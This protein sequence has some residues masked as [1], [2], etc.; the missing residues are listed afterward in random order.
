MSFLPIVERE[1]RVRSRKRLVYRV[2]FG[3]ALLTCILTMVLL[4]PMAASGNLTLGRILFSILSWA[5]FLLAFFSG[6]FL[7]VDSFAREQREGTLGL[8]FLTDLQ[9]WD[10][11]LG[12]FVSAF[13][14]SFYAMIA[15]FP[16]M[17]IPLLTGGVAGGEFWRVSLALVLTL[18]FSLCLG[19][20]ISSLHRHEQRAFAQM[21]G[22]LFVLLLLPPLTMALQR[23]IPPS[24]TGIL[25]VEQL[26][27]LHLFI[28]AGNPI[29]RD[30]WGSFRTLAFVTALLLATAMF[31]VPRL[32]QERGLTPPA[33]KP[34]LRRGPIGNCDPVVWL[35][36]NAPVV[37]SLAWF[38]G[39]GAFVT[40]V[41]LLAGTVPQQV[42]RTLA[43][44][45]FSP[46]SLLL[47][48]LFVYQASR[49]FTD[50]RRNSAIELL[51]TTPVTLRDLANGQWV[52]LRKIFMGP[53]ILALA[54]SIIPI[55]WIGNQPLLANFVQ[56]VG[57]G[58]L[59]GYHLVVIAAEVMALGWTGMWLS[60]RLK[61]PGWA[62]ALA[63]LLVLILPKFLFCLPSFISSLVLA[64]VMRSQLLD[65]SN[66]LYR[67]GV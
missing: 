64:A 19:L 27:P 24:W 33:Q 22:G 10:V 12:K 25:L 21:A 60:L 57:G 48:I 2:R 15:T 51:A 6:L 18:L 28:A 49:L 5:V 7:T 61:N 44:S 50:L 52:S 59:W 11:V 55:L 54:G 63:V 23:L 37:H 35:T 65:Y 13:L 67:V 46:F 43:W 4:L 40:V 31:F 29:G 9:T 14:P 58:F 3:I 47:K 34:A 56:W 39:L 53:G 8:M 36:G 17:A 26:S 62:P 32:W 16:A 41:I 38:I 20:A 45:G 1:L 66:R 42:L 30:Y